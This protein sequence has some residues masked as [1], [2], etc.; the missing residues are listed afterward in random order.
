MRVVGQRC[1]TAE[2]RINAEKDEWTK[3]S[4]GLVFYVSF[5][6]GF[7]AAELPAICKSLLLAPLASSNQWSAD[8][9]DAD[10]VINLVKSGAEQAVLVIPQA[11]LVCKL[12]REAR[13]L[14]YHKQ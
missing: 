13:S 8:H 6:K 2:V 1:E 10:C 5:E 3:G 14:K 11:S 12:E 4:K 7:C 9:S